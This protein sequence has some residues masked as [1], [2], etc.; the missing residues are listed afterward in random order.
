MLPSKALLHIGPFLRG[1]HQAVTGNWMVGR[2]QGC[3]NSLWHDSVRALRSSDFSDSGRIMSQITWS[4]R[5]ERIAAIALLRKFD[6][7][8]HSRGILPQFAV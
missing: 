7:V 4:T 5:L 3:G 6:W 1:G 2:F 8:A